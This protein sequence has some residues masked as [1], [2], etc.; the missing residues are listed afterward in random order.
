M[1]SLRGG[2]RHRWTSSHRDTLRKTLFEAGKKIGAESDAYPFAEDECMHGIVGH[3]AWLFPF[4]NLMKGAFAEMT[5]VLARPA[6]SI[7]H[8]VPTYRENVIL[9]AFYPFLYDVQN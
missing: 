5:P 6:T 8:K 2:A 7:I 9:V 4:A 3:G 1:Q